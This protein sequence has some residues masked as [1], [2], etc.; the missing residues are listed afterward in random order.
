MKKYRFTFLIFLLFFSCTK[1]VKIDIPG[2]EEQ[3][4]IDGYIETNQPP[5]VLLSR[6][7]DIYGLTTLDSFLQ[8]FVSGATVIVSDGT[9]TEQLIEICTDNLPPGFESIAASLFGISESELANYHLCGYTSFNPAIFGQVGKTYQLTVDFEGK[10]YTSSTELLPATP[11]QT[12]FWKEQVGL[13][14]YGFSYAILSDPPQKGDAY[15]WE[16]KRINKDSLGNPRDG[17]FTKTFTPVVDDAFFN[18]L[19][20]EFSYENPMSYKDEDLENKYKGYYQLGDSVV[21]KFSKMD[22]GVFNFLE[23]KY[24]QMQTGGSPFSSPANIPTNIQ[25]GALGLWAGYSSWYDTLY[26]VP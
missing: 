3:L 18:G 6:S 11:L 1:E 10:T 14:N 5:I 22:R 8:G 26:C 4:V 20:F 19:T 15:L 9:T 23:K 2:Y 12:T 24:M 7:K 13:P 21:I 25:G 17:K 16:V